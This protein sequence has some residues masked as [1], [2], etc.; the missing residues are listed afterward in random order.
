MHSMMFRE[1]VSVIIK[2]KSQ[3]RIN[4]D[5]GS[6]NWLLQYIFD[7]RIYDVYG[8]MCCGMFHALF[9]WP[10]TLL[11]PLLNYLLPIPLLSLVALVTTGVMRSWS[12][13]VQKTASHRSQVHPPS[14][15]HFLHSLSRSSLFCSTPYSLEMVMIHVLF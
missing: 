6:F 11:Y 13:H 4:L 9:Y 1:Y 3:A 10:P 14:V 15:I 12:W 7:T 8:H 5:F 2:L